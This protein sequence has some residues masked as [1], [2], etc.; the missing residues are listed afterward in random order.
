VNIATH[1][2]PTSITTLPADARAVTPVRRATYT[3]AEVCALLGISR[4]TAYAM[5]RA[6]AI[7]A[8]RLGTRWIIP[9]HRLD[10]WLN[11]D[12]VEESATVWGVAQ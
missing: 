10:T 12:P 6:G 7:P 4:A 3:I 8:R 9:R 2:T 5:L 11:S 1:A